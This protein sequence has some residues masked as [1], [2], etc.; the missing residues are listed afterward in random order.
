MNEQSDFKKTIL[1]TFGDKGQMNF[2]C[3]NKKTCVQNDV[4]GKR[5]QT[6]I[7]KVDFGN[8]IKKNDVI[9]GALKV[10]SNKNLK[11]LRNSATRIKDP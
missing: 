3:G 1:G 10:V 7:K 8:S 9:H 4:I 11:R 5:N 6:K 2:S